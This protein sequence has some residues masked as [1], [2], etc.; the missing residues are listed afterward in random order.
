MG[1]EVRTPSQR[2]RTGTEVRDIG[3]G[4]RLERHNRDRGWG[5]WLDTETEDGDGAEDS[6]STEDSDPQ[7]TGCCWFGACL[8]RVRA[9]KARDVVDTVRRKGR[10]ASSVLVSAICEVDPVLSRELRL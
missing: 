2:Q 10:K 1:T 3:W 7:R 9:D 8:T 4:R 5:R 6:V